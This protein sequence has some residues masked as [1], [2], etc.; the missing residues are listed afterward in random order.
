M[1][2]ERELTELVSVFSALDDWTRLK[3]VFALAAA[4]ELCVSDLALVVG[5]NLSAISTQ[6]RLLRGLGVVSRRHEGKMVFYFLRGTSVADLA[7]RALR[8]I[9]RG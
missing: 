6:L 8:H 1:P 5:M 3:I 4:G 2:R 9:T 7:K